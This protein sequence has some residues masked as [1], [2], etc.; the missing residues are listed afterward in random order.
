MTP[1]RTASSRQ[2][3]TPRLALRAPN[4]GLEVVVAAA[5]STIPAARQVLLALVA[6]SFI[7]IAC[8]IVIVTVPWLMHAR[9]WAICLPEHPVTERLGNVEIYAYEA[10][11]AV[12]DRFTWL[13]LVSHGQSL[14]QRLQELHTTDPV[15]H[16]SFTFLGIAIPL[17]ASMLKLT[18]SSHKPLCR[19]C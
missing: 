16:Q 1:T 18:S 8:R 9:E 4:R 19:F 11:F 13:D 15:S 12:D 6:I 3:M 14:A 5:E 7:L 17:P 2:G 10:W